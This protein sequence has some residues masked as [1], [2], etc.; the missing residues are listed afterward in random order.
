MSIFGGQF[1]GAVRIFRGQFHGAVTMLRV[2]FLGAV[3]IFRGAVTGRGHDVWGG[4]SR[5]R[6]GYFGWEF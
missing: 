1:E 4:S 5:M 3:M 2:Q 6:W